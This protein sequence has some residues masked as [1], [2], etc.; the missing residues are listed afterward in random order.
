[1]NAGAESEERSDVPAFARSL[2]KEVQDDFCD[3]G[4]AESVIA[5]AFSGA[6]DAVLRQAVSSVRKMSGT[7]KRAGSVDVETTN[8]L[9]DSSS[10]WL[11]LQRSVP[12][13]DV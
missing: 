6:D 7:R 12:A 2:M 3:A 1:M 5:V 13:L 8:A 9:I 4:M 10:G 11:L